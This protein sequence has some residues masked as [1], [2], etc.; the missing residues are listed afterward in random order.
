MVD[1]DVHRASWVDWDDDNKVSSNAKRN[2][3]GKGFFGGMW[4]WASA[5][6]ESGSHSLL[7][8]IAITR[9]YFDSMIE[10][11]SDGHGVPPKVGQCIIKSRS[12]EGSWVHVWTALFTFRWHFL[13]AALTSNLVASVLLLRKCCLA[14][15]AKLSLSSEA[16]FP[17]ERA[18]PLLQQRNGRWNIHE[19]G[20]TNTGWAWTKFVNKLSAP[21]PIPV[22][23]IW[24]LRRWVWG[25]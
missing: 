8:R 7:W 19:R 20:V 4:C 11:H 17:C 24:C 3:V 6:K 12:P 13:Y 14:A 9:S 16:L 23:P 21:H 25:F 2:F 18:S 1:V 22:G 15:T 5:K 10:P